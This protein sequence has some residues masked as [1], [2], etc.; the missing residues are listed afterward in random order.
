MSNKTSVKVLIKKSF[1]ILSRG[2]APAD[3]LL[4]GPGQR[5]GI[6]CVISAGISGRSGGVGSYTT[7]RI[8]ELAADILNPEGMM[9][10]RLQE[11]YQVRC[12]LP[13]PGPLLWSVFI[14]NRVL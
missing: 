2:T 11:Q 9:Q 13:T 5:R 1:K 8:C 14:T 6:A 10:R 12:R 7:S 3:A 4:G